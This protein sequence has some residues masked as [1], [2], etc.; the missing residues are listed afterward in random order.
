MKS[1]MD[2]RDRI[3]PFY[4]ILHPFSVEDVFEWPLP[5]SPV[6]GFDIRTDALTPWLFVGSSPKILCDGPHEKISRLA[7]LELYLDGFNCLLSDLD[8]QKRVDR[9]FCT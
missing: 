2:E 8:G 5:Y 6:A 7:G 4:G 1:P 3:G 9:F